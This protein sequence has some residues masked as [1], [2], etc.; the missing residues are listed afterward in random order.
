MSDSGPTYSPVQLDVYIHEM[1]Q[2]HQSRREECQDDYKII[3][4]S[5]SVEYIPVSF[6]PFYIAAPLIITLGQPRRKL[7]SYLV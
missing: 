7:Y 5:V 1:H 6:P 4:C 2:M 3:R